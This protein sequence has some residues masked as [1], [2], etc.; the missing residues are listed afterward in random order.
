MAPAE[1]SVPCMISSSFPSAASRAWGP[2]DPGPVGCD[3]SEGR[4]SA[5]DRC[6]GCLQLG[7]CT[8]TRRRAG[9]CCART[10]PIHGAQREVDSSTT[11]FAPLGS[12]PRFI[13]P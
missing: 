4:Y 2:S 13:P 9:R 8:C 7:D 6:D 11:F 3:K 12:G 1:S 10:L 5:L